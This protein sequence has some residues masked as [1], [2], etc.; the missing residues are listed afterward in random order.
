MASASSVFSGADAK[1]D[2]SS[3]LLPLRP[4]SL[5]GHQVSEQLTDNSLPLRADIGER[6][7]RV[8]DEGSRHSLHPLVR[9]PGQERPLPVT[10]VPQP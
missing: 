10:L 9:R 5:R 2:S 4:R 8:L 6:G 3:S 1:T 7:L